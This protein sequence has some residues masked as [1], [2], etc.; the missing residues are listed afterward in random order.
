M[1]KGNI[2][3]GRNPVSEYLKSGQNVDQIFFHEHIRQNDW[4]KMTLQLA[5]EQNIKYSFVPREKLNQ[6]AGKENHQGVV[7]FISPIRY[8][9]VEE[10]LDYA[11]KV[12]EKPFIIILDSVQDPHNL[13]AIIRTAAAVGVHGIILPKHGSVS[14][15]DTVYKT[16]AG[17]VQKCKIAKVTNLVQVIEKLKNEDIW[18][19][20]ADEKGDKSFFDTDFKG[21]IALVMGSEGKGLHQKVAEHCDFLINIPMKNRVESLNVSVS[22]GLLM[23]KVFESRR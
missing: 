16:S 15:T 1:D 9:T 4:M 13:G 6:L 21:G 3:F 14:V 10:I 20:G 17:T 12:N 2:I 8:A 5:K 11:R 19:Y 18:F 23:Y 22:A 7:A